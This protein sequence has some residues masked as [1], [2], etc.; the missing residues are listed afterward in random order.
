MWRTHTHAPFKALSCS[1]QGKYG[2]VCW[3][4]YSMGFNM[5]YWLHSCWVVSWTLQ[6]LLFSLGWIKATSGHHRKSVRN[7]VVYPCLLI[8]DLASS[9]SFTP[10]IISKSPAANACLGFVI[11]QQKLTA[12]VQLPRKLKLGS[13]R[14]VACA[15][16][17]HN[18]AFR[19]AS[20]LGLSHCHRLHD[21]RC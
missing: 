14:H 20:F 19:A 11:P 3:L 7:N 13:I 1:L 21:V 12:G 8:S 10:V 15:R 16:N 18:G 4:V 17:V 6:M 5:G 9:S 2:F